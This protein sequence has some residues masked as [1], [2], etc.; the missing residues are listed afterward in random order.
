MIWYFKIL[1][2]YIIINLLE[3]VVYIGVIF[4]SIFSD[5]YG[6]FVCI[7]ICVERFR[8]FDK[9]VRSSRVLV[10]YNFIKDFFELFFLLIFLI[11]NFDE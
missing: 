9:Y 8:F 7:N 4:W 11:D 3:R 1:V 10:E 2:D 6:F 5:N